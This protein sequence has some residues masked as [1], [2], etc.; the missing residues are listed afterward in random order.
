MLRFVAFSLLE[1]MRLQ[2]GV[3]VRLDRHLARMAQSARHFGFAWDEHAVRDAVAAEASSHP[4]GCRRVRLLAGRDG[5]VRVEST[6]HAPGEARPWRVGFARSP[7]D[8]RDP[9]LVNK[10]TSR[11]VYDEARRARPDLDDVLLWNRR[12]EVTES[13]IANLVVDIDGSLYTSPVASG[14]LP[15]VFRG[16]LLDRGLIR[17]RVLLKTDVVRAGRLYLVNSLREWIDAVLIEG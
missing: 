1:T 7:V 13:T 16:E 2:D 8:E 17:E 5:S 3:V 12:G 6:P 9:F 4:A 11:E 14:L 10:T 15:G